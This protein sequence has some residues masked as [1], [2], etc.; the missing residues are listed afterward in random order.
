LLQKARKPLLFVDVDGVISLFPALP[1]ER[2]PRPWLNVD[3]ILHVLS[4][5]AGGHLRD[6]AHDFELVWCTG[7]EEKAN[8]HLPR[9]LGLDGPLPYL[10]L[11]RDRAPGHRQWKLGPI[12][13]YAGERRL[14]W[15]DDDHDEECR[16]W[17]RARGGGTLLVTTRPDVGLTQEHV[18]T[19]TVWARSLD[20][21][22]AG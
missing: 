22:R 13:R 7:W 8:E 17:A 1:D 9:A 16:E 19:L 12:E 10:D 2:P 5:E 20:D 21:A 15:I 18:D 11:D 6:L 14:A 4:T 3:G